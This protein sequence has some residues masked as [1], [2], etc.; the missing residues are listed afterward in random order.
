MLYNLTKLIGCFACSCLHDVLF[1][2]AC[3]TLCVAAEEHAP[4][5]SP[6]SPPPTSPERPSSP[7]PSENTSPTGDPPVPQTGTGV[8]VNGNAKPTPPAPASSNGGGGKGKMVE[9]LY[10]IPVGK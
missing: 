4:P 1:D 6:T 10:D 3:L 8:Q 7:E 5:P 9:E 2:S